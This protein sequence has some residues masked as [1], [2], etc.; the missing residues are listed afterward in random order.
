MYSPLCAQLP[1]RVGPDMNSSLPRV[2][3]GWRRWLVWCCVCTTGL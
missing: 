2:S 1:T 3:Y